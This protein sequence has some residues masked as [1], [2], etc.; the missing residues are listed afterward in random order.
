MSPNLSIM[1]KNEFYAIRS[2]TSPLDAYVQRI[3][4][5]CSND[6]DA[7]SIITGYEGEGKSTLAWLLCSNLV[8]GWE[9]RWKDHIAF[10]PLEYIKKSL[11]KG[12]CEPMVFDEAVAGLYNRNS[13]RGENKKLNEFMYVCRE[14]NLA[15]FFVFPRVTAF[16]ITIVDHRA[17]SWVEIIDRGQALIRLRDKNKPIGEAKE[18]QDLY[19]AFPVV[20]KV[21]W[22]KVDTD[23]FRE[24]KQWKTGMVQRI[25]IEALEG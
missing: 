12:S 15:H 8:D 6:L 1:P 3:Q 13:M 7:V 14:R 16:D 19:R 17:W 22:D 2:A 10:D 18:K 25:G 9:D 4:W 20:A 23:G 5:R 24:Y 11:D 21:V